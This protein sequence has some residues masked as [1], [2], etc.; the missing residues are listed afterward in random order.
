MDSWSCL[1]PDM[2]FH[3]GIHENAHQPPHFCEHV[4]ETQLL[5]LCSFSL[6]KEGNSSYGG[7][8]SVTYSMLRMEGW[9]PSGLKPEQGNEYV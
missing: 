2:P 8:G 9:R 4:P 5:I 3:A 7:A 1:S 6:I